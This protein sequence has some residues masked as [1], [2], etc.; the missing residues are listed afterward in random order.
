MEFD[1][2]PIEVKVAS[3]DKVFFLLSKNLQ[4]LNTNRMHWL[5]E[6][7]CNVAKNVLS[8]L[9]SGNIP[10]EQILPFMR[11][12]TTGS[13]ST[14]TATSHSIPTSIAAPAAN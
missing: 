12:G 4:T 7:V 8:K 2:S 5:S 1:V 10:N 6:K 9:R 13:Y 14:T 11:C 3:D